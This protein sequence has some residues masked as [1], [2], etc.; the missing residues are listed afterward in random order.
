MTETG[1]TKNQVITML[2]KS[3]HGKL[4]EYGP[5]GR[6]AVVSDP[7]FFSKLIAWNQVNGQIR[8]SK[9]ALP[10]IALSHPALD[11]EF[12][13]NASAHIALLDPRNMVRA[14]RFA[15]ETKIRSQAMRRIAKTYL[16]AK[17]SNYAKWERL[18]VQHRRS[19]K[20][21]YA[22]NH[23]KPGTMADAILFKGERPKGSVFES[24]AD[25]KNMSNSEAAGTIMERRI[26]FLIAMGALGP[27]AKEPDLV[28]AL[29]DRMSPTELVTNS[30]MLERLGIKTDPML[31][32]SYEKALTKA[33]TSKKAT[34]K[35]T[36]AAMAMGDEG[37]SN[38]LKDLQEKQIKAIGGI[39]GNWLV[40]GDKSPSMEACIDAARH[41]AATLA[42]MVTGKVHLVFFDSVPLYVDVT[43]LTYDQVLKATKHVKVGG[44]TSIGCGLDRI[45]TSGIEVDGIA[46]VSDAQENSAPMFAERYQRY[47]KQ[48]DK[49]PS[50]YL[51]RF[52]PGMRGIGDVDLAQS[53]NRIGVSVNEFDMRGGFDFYSL[54]NIAMTMRANRFSLVDEIMAQ[55]LLSF[56]EMFDVA[57]KGELQH[58]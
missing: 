17:E 55:P 40:L 36:Q 28:M 33:S 11:S 20:E 48:F 21:L 1:L 23:I 27:K 4:E 10:V 24:I 35:T 44:G 52:Q 45:L 13:S 15:K 29:M 43:G 18:A 54:P 46:I 26:P 5:V 25:L 50:V 9:V 38:K 41:L 30:K 53:M 51:Y 39:D 7:E 58:A 3:P 12:V 14:V 49:E 42:K 31:R 2:A 56:E 19:M 47:V 34:L 57:T 16:R 6:Q 32:A 8:D 22:L 37:L